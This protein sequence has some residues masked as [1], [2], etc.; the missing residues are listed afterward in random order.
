VISLYEIDQIIRDKTEVSEEEQTELHPVI[1][2]C[3][4][5]YLDMF[6]KKASNTLPLTQPYDHKIKLMTES[7]T[8]YCL[9]YKMSLE[10]LEAVKQYI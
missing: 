1:P 3:Y 10:E 4:H 9:L 6:L 5:N 8:R 7:S 2:E